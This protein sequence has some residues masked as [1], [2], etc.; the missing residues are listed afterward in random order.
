M[1]IKT[2]QTLTIKVEGED[3]KNLKSALDKIARGDTKIGFSKTPLSTD[4]CK[5]IKSLNEKL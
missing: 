4:E 3:A 2:S 5:V 1:E